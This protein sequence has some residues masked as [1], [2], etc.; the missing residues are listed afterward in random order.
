MLRNCATKIRRGRVT[1][2]PLAS[3]GGATPP[4]RFTFVICTFFL[5]EPIIKG[6]ILVR[7]L[8]LYML[9]AY[10]EDTDKLQEDY[11]KALEVEKNKI[12]LPQKV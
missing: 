4:L 7:N 8:L 5:H 9:D 6:K 3:K 10:N 1:R 12:T 2:P 11:A